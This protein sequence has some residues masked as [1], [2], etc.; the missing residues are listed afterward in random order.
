MPEAARLLMLLAVVDGQVVGAGRAGLNTWTSEVGAAHAMVVVHPEHRRRGIGARLHDAVE[1]HL[2]DVGAR[3]VE[4]WADDDP[5]IAAWCA[6]L[7]YER[8]HELRFSRLDLSNPDALPPVPPMPAGVTVTSY[9]EVGPRV[10]YEMDV[11]TI[12]DEPGEMT[13][14]SIPYEEWEA[15][16]WNDVLIDRDASAVVLVDGRAAAYTVVD[17][18]RATGRMWSGGTGTRRE[19]RGRG[20]AKI[21]KSVALR[22]AI[23]LGITSA[24]T[25]NDEVNRPMLAVNEWLG[26]RAC[27]T[28]W[29][30][31][32]TL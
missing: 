11:E 12:V 15:G 30:N 22:R 17:A 10:A 3:R 14:D 25:S 2:R 5:G 20:L 4:L 26:Y 32:K 18:D 28:E 9:T 29:A 1:R 6:R 31:V 27:A 8:T 7:G 16:H 23:A 13:I 24:Y 21:A 19:Y